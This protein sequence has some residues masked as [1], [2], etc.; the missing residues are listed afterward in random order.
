MRANVFSCSKAELCL[1]QL[2]EICVF[3]AALKVSAWGELG[4]CSSW[5]PFGTDAVG[6][7]QLSEITH[8]KH[9]SF[10]IVLGSVNCKRLD[11]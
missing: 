9:H 10:M 6:T 2:V 4:L 11:R 8:T 3:A 5:S 1:L 7:V